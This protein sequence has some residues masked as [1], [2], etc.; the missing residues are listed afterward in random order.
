MTFYLNKND[1]QVQRTQ[2]QDA[3]ADR[4]MEF[5]DVGGAAGGPSGS[6]PSGRVPGSQIRRQTQR[7]EESHR[8]IQRNHCNYS[9]H[10]HII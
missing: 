2:V 7:Q 8:R 5:G 4:R 10:L 9:F 1:L 6:G 3:S